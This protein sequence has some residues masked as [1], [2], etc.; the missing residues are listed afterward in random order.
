MPSN[1]DDYFDEDEY[2]KN[3]LK[4]IKIKNGIK[5]GV[6]TI[7]ISTAIFA[8][9]SGLALENGVDHTQKLCPYT[10]IF[11]YEHQVNTINNKYNGCTAQ[12]ENIDVIPEGFTKETDENGNEYYVKRVYPKYEKIYEV[13]AGYHIELNERG[14]K[15]GVARDADGHM[16]GIADVKEV[17]KVIIPDNATLEDG[18][19]VIK[20]PVQTEKIIAIYNSDGETINKIPLNK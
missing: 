12:L 15:I 7:L 9:V 6:G 20:I 1:L 19:A 18:M 10:K 17:I 3:E 8:G 5:K 2:Y 11:G 14:E 4:K 16:N 13:P